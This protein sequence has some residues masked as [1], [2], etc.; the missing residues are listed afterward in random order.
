MINLGR[1]IAIVGVSAAGKSWFG[2]ALAHK[3]KLPLTHIDAVMWKPGWNYIGDEKT[4]TALKEISSGESWIIEGY[5]DKDAF[6]TVLN[7]A[8]SILYLDYARYLPA[9]RYIKRC[10]AHRTYPRPELEG[11]P[12]TFKFESLKRVW[13]KSEVYHLNKFLGKIPTPKKVIRLKSPKQA[14]NLLKSL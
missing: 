2:R 5:I 3:T 4:V 9:W 6:D 11:S 7:R 12:D 1:R 13:S 14:S 8:D 10:F